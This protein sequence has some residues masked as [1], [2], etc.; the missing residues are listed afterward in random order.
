MKAY[1]LTRIPKDVFDLVI[2]EQEKIKKKKGTNQFSFE[3]TLYNMIRDLKR[4]RDEKEKQFQPVS[5]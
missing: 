4:C 5:Q 2:D 1:T 3:S